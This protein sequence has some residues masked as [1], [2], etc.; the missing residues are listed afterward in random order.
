MFT[1]TLWALDSSSGARNV[2]INLHCVQEITRNT[3]YKEKAAE[4][5]AASQCS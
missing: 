3:F 5:I 1:A 4:I 2:I